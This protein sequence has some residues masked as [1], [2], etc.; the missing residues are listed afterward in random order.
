MGVISGQLLLDGVI[1]GEMNSSVRLRWFV[2]N[3]MLEAME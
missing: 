1:Q 3:M 2:V